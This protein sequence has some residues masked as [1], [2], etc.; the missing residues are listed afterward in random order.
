LVILFI[1][2]IYK[3]NKDIPNLYCKINGIKYL[4]KCIN[5]LLTNKKIIYNNNNLP[6]ISV[7]I[8]VYN[9]E[10][11]IQITIKSIQNQNNIDFE[12]ILINDYSQDNTSII[13]NKLQK[14]DQRIIIMNN[15]KNMGTF[16]SRSI[17]V[18]NSK[19]KYIFCIDN[20]D[21]FFDEN[22]FYNIYNKAIKNNYDIIEFKSYEIPNYHPHVKEIKESYFN[23]HKNNIFIQQ[24]ELGL[25]PI[26][27][28]FNYYPNDFH[29]WGKCIKS[30]IYK[31]AVNLIGEK[32]I[33]FYNCWTEDISIIFIIFNI[34]QSFF[35]LDK[36]GIFHLDRRTS[37]TYKLNEEH[38]FIS[39]LF[40]LDIIID[41]INNIEKNYKYIV[42]KAL[43]IIDTNNINLLNKENKNYSNLIF[44]KLFN[45]KYININDKI[46]IKK[47]FKLIIY[48]ILNIFL[49]D[50]NY[51]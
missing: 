21:V 38:K 16:Y 32:R 5:N 6:I 30:F 34:A 10:N 17:G 4:Q 8:P 49:I 45:L 43:S 1:L 11:D 20:D 18:L 7:I 50:F 36:Y 25:F 27:R 2:F 9:C 44:K 46:K 39:E 47:K 29:I 22:L 12:I 3:N 35:F 37:A 48:I 19:G 28:D 42:Q 13:I 31:N 23:H 41:F 24:P 51:I 15:K 26:S 14:N 40:L 33:K